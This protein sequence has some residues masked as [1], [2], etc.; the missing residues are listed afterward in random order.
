MEQERL[1]ETATRIFA[2][3]GY[4]GASLQMIAEAAGDDIHSVRQVAETKAELYRQVMQRAHTAEDEAMQD[5]VAHFTPDRQGIKLLADA[6]LDF[7]ASH[8]QALALWQHGWMGDAADVTGVDVFYVQ[9]RSTQIAD[10]IRDRVPPDVDPDYLVWS[11]MWCVYGFLN[12]GAVHQH[13]ELPHRHTPSSAP[14]RTDTHSF[15]AFLHVMIDRMF[16]SS[17]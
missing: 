5:A 3:L 16:A 1:I 6:F 8:P 13:G 9:P 12:T 15:Q 4:D 14:R 10:K 7:F 2:E 11:V 17:P